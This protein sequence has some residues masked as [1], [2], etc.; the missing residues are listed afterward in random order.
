MGNNTTD[1]IMERP[2]VKKAM[3]LLMEERDKAQSELKEA[4][5]ELDVQMWGL[6]KTN[7][8]I[9]LLYKE[10]AE[11]NKK[12]QELDNLKSEFVANVSHELRTP[13]AIMK[14][15]ALIILD[16]IPGRLTK[17]QR[18]YVDIIRGNIE[19][20]S[21]LINDILDISRIEAGEALLKKTPANI[22]TLANNVVSALKAKADVKRIKIKFL[23]EKNLPAINIDP[24]KII[25]VFTNLI[26][27]AIK[28]TPQKG[29][30]TIWIK[31][32]KDR[33][34]CGVADTGPG[35]AK[36]NMEKIFGRFQQF[37]RVAGSGAKGTGLGLAITKE[38]VQMHNGKIWVKSALKK[39]SEFFF[40][41]PKQNSETLKK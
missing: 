10:L 16:E 19:R 38:L 11:K 34:E 15:F 2:A 7:E 29:R 4:K 22:T 27:N 30:I 37:D 28:F 13:L 18:E 23:A 3:L 1:N 9:K 31:D 36:E 5:K 26:D 12:L 40:T 25:Q 33:L 6:K 41:L 32:K 8:A 17:D 20:L 39:G 14:E 35:I 24:D 21:R